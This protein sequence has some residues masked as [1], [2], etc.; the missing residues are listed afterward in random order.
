MKILHCPQR[1]GT[2]AVA[3]LGF[4]LVAASV[5]QARACSTAPYLGEV[6]VFAGTYCPPNYVPADGSLLPISQNGS[7]FQVLNFTYGGDGQTTFG[8]PN[9][10]GRSVIGTNVPAENNLLSVSL[11][12]AV[13]SSSALLTTANLPQHSHMINQLAD[14]NAST[15]Q[16]YLP[17]QTNAT[18]RTPTVTPATIYLTNA[19]AS[20]GGTALMGLYT[21]TPPSQG[22]T[23]QLLVAVMPKSISLSGVAEASSLTANAPVATQAPAL[24]LTHCIAING[25]MPPL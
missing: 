21:T 3:I 17:V 9:L 11:G 25:A 24:A 1:L 23:A 5:N 19:S 13:G 15:P 10:G 20:S 14:W 4:G 12:Q 16:G 2:A 22:Q 8:L 18:V 7:L 6:C